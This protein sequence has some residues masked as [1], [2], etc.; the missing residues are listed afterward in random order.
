MRKRAIHGLLAAALLAALATAARAADDDDAP[1]PKPQ[2]SGFSALWNGWFGSKPKPAEKVEKKPE[3][4][5]KP[6]GPTAA[7]RDALMRRER[8]A[9]IRRLQVCDRLRAVAQL[10]ND[11]DM[12]R[13]LE[14]LEEQ[15]DALYKQRAMGL[16]QASVTDE[17]PPEKPKPR[18]SHRNRN[19][20]EDE[21]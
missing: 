20:R 1:P 8:D 6:T 2:P 4:P 19:S 14:E 10:H 21:Q 17:A 16:Q 7:E 13:R 18:G 15:V 9:N 12:L 5:A 11:E 3:P